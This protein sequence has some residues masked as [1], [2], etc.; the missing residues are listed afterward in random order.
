VATGGLRLVKH[1]FARDISLGAIKASNEPNRGVKAL[2][3]FRERY[4]FL[5][6]FL[7]AWC[8]VAVNSGKRCFLSLGEI[9]NGSPRGRVA[10]HLGAVKGDAGASLRLL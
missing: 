3:I 2:K 8:Y 9:P 6:L 7:F 5:W 4:G 10:A 1:F